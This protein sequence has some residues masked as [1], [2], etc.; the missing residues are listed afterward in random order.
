M[1]WHY[2][3]IEGFGLI[4]CLARMARV[5]LDHF[6]QTAFIVPLTPQGTYAMDRFLYLNNSAS[7]CI[8]DDFYGRAK[9]IRF[10]DSKPQPQ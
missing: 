10:L 4:Y 9:N 2:W 1:A 6:A 8:G 3:G 5:Y 7:E